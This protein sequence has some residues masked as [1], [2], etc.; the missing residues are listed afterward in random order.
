MP[1]GPTLPL[2][3]FHS[4]G[5]RDLALLKRD[6]LDENESRKASEVTRDERT[7]LTGRQTE[8]TECSRQYERQEAV[9]SLPTLAALVPQG[10]PGARRVRCSRRS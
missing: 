5:E 3:R 7:R 1:T 8:R 10:R 9:G 6:V 4:R 2:V